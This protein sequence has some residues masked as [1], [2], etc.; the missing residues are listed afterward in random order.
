MQ[1]YGDFRLIPKN[2]ED[3]SSSCCDGEE[4]L[5]QS[6]GTR[7]NLVVNKRKFGDFKCF[8]YLCTYI[9]SINM[10]HRIKYGKVGS[11]VPDNA[12]ATSEEFEREEVSDEIEEIFDEDTEFANDDEALAAMEFYDT[13]DDTE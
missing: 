3:S 7:Q 13:P 5:R 6:G 9:N 1:R 12:K 8:S 10:R 4:D 2:S 11:F